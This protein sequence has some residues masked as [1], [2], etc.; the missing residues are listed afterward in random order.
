MVRLL[1]CRAPTRTGTATSQRGPLDQWPIGIADI[2][3]PGSV[4]SIT[5]EKNNE[6]T[7]HHLEEWY[8]HTHR[9]ALAV[10]HG[11]Q[12]LQTPVSILDQKT[13]T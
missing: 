6:A 7:S 12:D 10:M 11:F 5:D 1:G 4:V 13:Q 2:P 8:T 9:H 3:A